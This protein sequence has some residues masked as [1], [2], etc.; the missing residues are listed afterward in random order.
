MH[1][2]ALFP[3]AMCTLWPH[4]DTSYSCTMRSVTGRGFPGTTLIM[5]D[6]WQIATKVTTCQGWPLGKSGLIWYGSLH[7]RVDPLARVV[8][9]DMDHC[10]QDM[11]HHV[12]WSI[13]IMVFPWRF[14]LLGSWIPLDMPVAWIPLDMPVA[15]IPLDMPVAWI[16]LDM[17]VAWMHWDFWFLGY[18]LAGGLLHK[19]TIN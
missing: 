3:C 12:Y 2:M 15:W 14:G 4:L 10:N 7:A 5:G 19:S 9:Y 6:L 18:W 8:S 17:P 1:F 16:P 11:K 13:C